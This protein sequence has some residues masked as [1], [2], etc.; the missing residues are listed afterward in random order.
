MRHVQT[1]IWAP[2]A[3]CNPACTAIENLNPKW[4]LFCFHCKLKVSFRFY[5]VFNVT[6]SFS[7]CFIF[8][9]VFMSYYTFNSVS[10]SVNCTLGVTI[11]GCPRGSEQANASF[12]GSEQATVVYFYE[13][14]HKYARYMLSSAGLLISR[15]THFQSARIGLLVEVA[16]CVSAT[17]SLLKFLIERGNWIC[18]RRDQQ[19]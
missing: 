11:K 19:W 17:P 2:S 5:F 8:I 1:K 10:V 15:T 4:H 7:Y 6:F 9:S 14:R 16:L 18:P 12:G 3:D 13:I